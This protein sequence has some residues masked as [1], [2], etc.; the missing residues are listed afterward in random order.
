MRRDDL[1][2]SLDPRFLFLFTFSSEPDHN[3]NSKS[4]FKAGIDCDLDSWLN[5]FD[6]CARGIKSVSPRF[7]WGG[8]GS[9][10]ATSTTAFLT[11]MIKHV[12]AANGSN[13]TA[14]DFIQWHDK[15]V[16]TNTALDTSIAETIKATNPA[17][18]A[19]TPIG[20][21]EVD[22]LG[23]W[24]KVEM[25][26]GDAMYPAAVA[27]VLNT[28]QVAL[29]ERMT[30]VEYTY[31]ANDNAFQNY[32]N[33]WFDQRTLTVRFLQN[34]TGA[35]EVLRKPVYNLMG[36]LAL[37]GDTKHVVSNVPDPL[38]SSVGVICTSGDSPTTSLERE[39]A[40]LV[41]NSGGITN[42]STINC[43][44]VLAVTL[45]NAA[46][47]L[48]SGRAIV[49]HYR[50]DQTHGNPRSQWAAMGGAANPYPSPDQLA[51]LR[52]ASELSVISVENLTG[53]ASPI[54]LSTTLPQ[55]GVS[56][57]HICALASVGS[58][59]PLPAP[60]LNVALRVTPTQNP[61]TVFVR[62]DVS[63][64]AGSGCIATY[65]VLYQRTGGTGTFT[66]INTKDTIFTAH[67]HAQSSGHTEPP[68]RSAAWRGPGRT[69]WPVLSTHAT[70]CYAV[71]A[72]SVWGD[73]GPLSD[74]VC[75][76]TNRDRATPAPVVAVAEVGS[77][78]GGLG[79][80]TD[81]LIHG[82]SVAA[83][84]ST[85]KLADGSTVFVLGNGIVSRTL[86]ANITTGLLGT[87]SIKVLGGSGAGEKLSQRILPE[88]LFS[89]NGVAV[90]VGGPGPT[91]NDDVRPRAMFGS[92]N[93]S[94][95]AV[96]AGGFHHVPGARG[97]DPNLVWPAPGLRAD[98]HHTLEC[99]AV[100]AGTGTLTVTTV[101]ELYDNTSA[102]GRRILL[103]HTCSTP[104]F[105]FNMS[106]SVLSVLHDRDITT[107]TDATMASGRFVSDLYD[108]TLSYSTNG[109][110]LT[111]GRNPSE[112]G[113]GVSAWASDTGVFESYLVVECVYDVHFEADPVIRG[114]R[115]YGLTIARAMHALAPQ[116]EQNPV[117]VSGVCTGGQTVSPPD[118]VAGSSGS[119]CYD[120]EGLA[121][122]KSLVA[123]C[124]TAGVEM[125]VF[126][127]NMN[128][129]LWLS[130]LAFRLNG[131]VTLSNL[132][133]LLLQ[134]ALQ[135]TWRSMIANE[136][137]SAA[138]I[139][140]MQSIVELAHA[141]GV[142]VGAYELLLNARSATAL[143]Q[144]CVV[145]YSRVQHSLSH[146]N[147]SCAELTLVLYGHSVHPVTQ[148]TTHSIPT[149][150]L[151]RWIPRCT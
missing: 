7:L 81:W 47:K 147:S 36:L 148:P 105:I 89:V 91:S 113:P 52:Q 92:A 73:R 72:V 35:T 79:N 98:F 39:V 90:V 133:I 74:P 33:V 125:L 67:V 102:F 51:T 117:R 55:P 76:P 10:G 48:G 86:I 54:T 26:R 63:A 69:Q 119:W 115:R 31:H 20:N 109:F 70:G 49:T 139:S 14:L 68:A 149:L 66:R 38:N 111:Q 44:V 128:V 64:A 93:A 82:C 141:S 146:L 129:R 142:E 78:C 75:V 132:L 50:I 99:S 100:A 126:A 62:W 16:L 11:A 123:Q 29:R 27:R 131:S 118:G 83:S 95:G 137:Q 112:F 6:A 30:G 122:I 116:V 138:N 46:A 65:E 121:G 114:M 41:Y 32:G 19:S 134:H 120:A 23:G 151:T 37:L 136:F 108:A 61:P 1:L 101:L 103:S 28:H 127:Q 88:T 43:S 135:E 12:A 140:F 87:S 110:A 45:H 24:D 40:V 124:G 5:Y 25:W 106:V 4:K 97:S 130:H 104:V 53:T 144:V 13:S 59:A 17:I 107:H 34:N 60:V 18:A 80:A 96:K 71:R 58:R 85:T 8:P 145:E 21:E 150:D 42:C 143:N 94:R 56:L 15:G 9:G 57:F 22:P 3:C 77:A 84:M 2:P